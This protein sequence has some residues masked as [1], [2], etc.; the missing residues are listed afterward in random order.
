MLAGLDYPRW[1]LV[2]IMS[3]FVCGAADA[4]RLSDD[5]EYQLVLDVGFFPKIVELD[6][7][8]TNAVPVC[9][10]NVPSSAA[11]TAIPRI[12]IITSDSFEL[13]IQSMP[14]TDPGVT[15]TVH[16][17][18]AEQ[19]THTLA[20]GRQ[21]Q[22]ITTFVTNVL[23]N[24]AGGWGDTVD[25]SASISA[26]FTS[27]AVLGAVISSNDNRATAFHADDCEGR[28]NEPFLS[29]VGDGICVGYHIGQQTDSPAYATE[30]VG[31]IIVE[32]GSGTVNNVTYEAQ[33]GPN[34]IDGVGNNGNTYAVGGDFEVGVASMA[35]ENGGQGGWA[36]LFGADPLPANQL[37]L[38]VEEET[39][40]GDTTR[41]HV[42]EVFD[43]WI[44]RDDNAPALDLTKTPIASTFA[45][46]GETVSY[47]YLV[48]NTGNTAINE[49]TVADNLIA[50]VSCPVVSLE[51]GES[52]VCTGTYVITPADVTAGSV[53]NTAVAGGVPTGGTLSPATDSATVTIT[54]GTA[55]LDVQKTM[56]VFDPLAEGL[57]AVPGNDVLY[58]ITVTNTGT[59]SVDTDT[60]FLVD[61][62]PDEVDFFN[63]DVNGV[64]TGRI[65]FTESGTALS[66]DPFLD[67]TFSDA[68]VRP[69]D[70]SDCNYVPI[71]G[72]DPDVRFLCFAPKGILNAASPDPVFQLTFRVRLN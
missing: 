54:P 25:I 3:L 20:D 53:T 60:I 51:L 10:Y 39:V 8:Y 50:S 7:S 29:G 42:A 56:T 57:Y 18:I 21:F 69:I 49:L 14:N 70:G 32:R 44:F 52:T 65:M 48:Q 47:D 46:A 62:L 22:A 34:A 23:G 72:Y 59:G 66:F 43:Y 13:S 64:G 55:A 6:N 40:A 12:G 37:R 38:A 71:N 2:G 36:V 63:G 24:T 41:S 61:A 1:L 68:T 9:T 30:T 5:L 28:G 16:C 26:G 17:L 27:P 15:G 58:T 35:G 31:V 33:R 19:G 67:V 45:E 4:G 11:P